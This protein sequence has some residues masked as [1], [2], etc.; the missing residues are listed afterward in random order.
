MRIH[1]Y[2]CNMRQFSVKSINSKIHAKEYRLIELI[3]KNIKIRIYYINN[4]E[5]KIV[6]LNSNVEFK[7]EIVILCY[8]DFT[9]LII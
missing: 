5:Q 2:A 6:I 8:S 3:K 9:L 7:I 1:L 4:N